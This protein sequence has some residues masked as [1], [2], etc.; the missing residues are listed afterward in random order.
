[1]PEGYTHL[2][3]ARRAA[4]FA[5]IPI[6]DE[7]AF[8][9][10]ANGPDMLFCYRAWRAAESRG[11]DLPA[12]GERL[13]NENTGAF[14]RWMVRHARGPVQRSYALGFLSH[15]AADCTLHPYV[16]FLCEE[17]QPFHRR[18]GHGYFEIGL[19]SDLHQR[20][21]GR[22]QV[23]VDDSTPK[24]TG[25]KLAAV[26]AL[27]QGAIRAA[28]GVAVS[29]EALADAFFHTRALRRLFVS[30]FRIK[31]ALFWLVEPA[32]GGR[33][34]VTAHIT[35]ARLPGGRGKGPGLPC[36][37]QNPF[38][39]RRETDD[40]ETLLQKAETRSAAYMLAARG[41]WEGKLTLEQFSALIGSASYLSGLPDEASDPK[42]T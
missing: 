18:G 8:G 34:A 25:A 38:T 7:A 3:V 36:P 24:L 31:Y 19:D 21:T 11:E 10:G 35:P 5:D 42:T 13:H 32:F 2:R 6:E 1:M 12:I 39:G 27:L 29:R 4:S 40:L 22:P 33:G 17:G 28:L 16:A 30:R 9:C 20:D 23:P 15:Y 26:G 37:W 41:S 14:L